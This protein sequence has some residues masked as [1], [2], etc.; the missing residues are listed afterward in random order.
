M[1]ALRIRSGRPLDH[2]EAL[3]ESWLAWVRGHPRLLG[4]TIWV[5]VFGL[6]LFGLALAA[7][8]VLLVW[9]EQP[10]AAWLMTLV[11]L[12]LWSGSGFMLWMAR[13][14][15]RPYAYLVHRR[16]RKAQAGDPSARWA[17]VS[18][19]LDGRQ[20]PTRDAA[21]AVWWLRQLA[22]D[23]DPEAAFRLAGHL[24]EGHGILKDVNQAKEWLA[25][26]AQQNHLGA[27]QALA[28]LTAKDP[29]TP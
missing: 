11:G 23:G 7:I 1:S 2:L 8:P 12:G 14:P 24:R 3:W 28:A 19:Y 25:K 17:L 16:I 18:A 13:S 26:A 29:S 15:A 9:G 20:G 10:G 21:Q 27:R 5:A 6:T 22:L 4:G